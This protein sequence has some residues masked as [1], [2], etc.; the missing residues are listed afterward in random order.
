MARGRKPR[1]ANL[2]I[3]PSGATLPPMSVAN[4]ELA[5]RGYEAVARG[6]LDPI[7]EL[8][9][10]DVRWHG[11]DPDS[12]GS[13]RSRD[14]ALTFLRAALER[15][16]VGR[17]VDLIDAGD[18]VVIIMQPPTVD[19][20]T[21]PRRANVTTFRDGKVVEMVAYEN[22]EAALTAAGISVH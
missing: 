10:D 17:L 8:L 5:R 21:P 22:P 12:I 18:D 14:E 15:R 20:V 2:D 13:C 16:G 4:V 3:A 19:G 9:A 11:G 6:D 7:S 1:A